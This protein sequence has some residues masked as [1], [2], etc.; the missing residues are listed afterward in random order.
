MRQSLLTGI[1]AVAFY[2]APMHAA[3]VIEED[4]SRFVSGSDIAPDKE[5]PVIVDGIVPAELTGTPGWSGMGVYQAGG[6]AYISAG[7]GNLATPAM[8]LSANGG[9]YK[10][11]FRAKADAASTPLIIMDTQNGSGYGFATLTDEW[12]EYSMTMNGGTHE[13]VIVFSGMYGGYCIDDIVIDDGGVGIPVL[14]PATDFTRGSFTANWEETVGADSYALNVFTLRYDPVTTIFKRDYLL[15]GYIVEGTSH[16]V[17]GIDFGTPYYY[18][19]SGRQDGNVTF[20]QEM[21]MR[22][23]PEAVSAP[24]AY[25]A[26]E[27]GG[28][29]FTGSW[30][31]SDLATVYAMHVVKVHTARR[32]ESYDIVNTDFSYIRTEG[33]VDK[34]QKELQYRLDGDWEVVMPALAQGMLGLNNQDFSL[35]DDAMLVSPVY[36]LSVGGGHVVISFDAMGRRNMTGGFVAVGR[37]TD[38]GGVEYVDR[39]DF[40]VTEDMAS[41]HF[42]FYGGTARSFIIVSS[43]MLGMLFIDNLRVSVDMNA[44][45]SLLVPVRTYDTEYTS[46]TASNLGL[47]R[48]DIAGYYV[49]GIYRDNAGQFP[50][51]VSAMSNSVVVSGLSG[52]SDTDID[53]ADVSVTVVG[54]NIRISNPSGCCVGVCSADG[55]RIA[56]D[57]SGA[58]T[59]NCDELSPGIYIVTV[60][61]QVF[62]VVVD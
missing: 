9:N 7:E 32:A 58:S 21:P 52:I 28:D 53:A 47:G 31:E 50:E 33:T 54:R 20:E 18:T 13:S 3:V 8:N 2:S 22:A 14:L 19:V 60:G 30:S 16:I 37:Y 46:C 35:F 36:D 29:S 17:E 6:S 39:K 48:D 1:F 40:D 24:V 38:A 45:E 59:V 15:E 51:V 49:T 62:K 57:C 27:V 25:A 10:I 43:E 42:D 56:C 44:G 11:M 5:S 23:I 26:T 34:P 55:R 41:F 4:F 61:T 12:A